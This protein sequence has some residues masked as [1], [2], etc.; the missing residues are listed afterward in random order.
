MRF[1]KTMAITVLLLACVILGS[2]CTLQAGKT[3]PQGI[4]GEPG[5][6]LVV[7]TG[8]VAPTGSLLSGY[9]VT[10]C[11]WNATDNQYEIGFT[12]TSSSATASSDY[13]GLVTPSILLSDNNSSVTS[14]SA[15]TAFLGSNLLIVYL[16]DTNDVRRQS[17]FSFV[18]LDATL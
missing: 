13:A 5:P 9:N 1:F 16:T 17:G 3:G 6:N 4:Q 11:R 14:L 12:R 15:T 7:T 10:L 8:R 2:A 18:V